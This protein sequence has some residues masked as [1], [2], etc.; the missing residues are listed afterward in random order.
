MSRRDGK[1]EFGLDQL[2]FAG[3]AARQ[4]YAACQRLPQRADHEKIRGDPGLRVARP[5]AFLSLRVP[6]FGAREIGELEI[7]EEDLHELFARQREHEVV[8]AAAFAALVATT[9][10]ARA[11]GSRDPVAGDVFAIAGE[12]E[13]AVAAAAEAER[14]LG[15]VLFGTR[16]F[17]ALLHVGQAA[18]ADH[19]LHRGFDLRLVPAQEA[20][21]VYGALAASVGS[22]IDQMEHRESRGVGCV[23]S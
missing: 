13:L 15:D 22:A 3:D 21:A 10:A 8:L 20:L 16:H 9:T 2:G 4:R 23:S 6:H 5:D 17:A 19:L 1:R 18:L 7:V 11:F 14:R 12:H